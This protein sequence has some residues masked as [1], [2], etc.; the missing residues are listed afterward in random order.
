MT[1]RTEERAAQ[2][3][4]DDGG[5]TPSTSVDSPGLNHLDYME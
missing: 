5:R 2:T 4:D 3:S 1:I